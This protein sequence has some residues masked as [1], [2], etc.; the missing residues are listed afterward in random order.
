MINRIVESLIEKRLNKG[1]AIILLGP[2]QTGKTTLL[3][4]IAEK[5]GKF[6]MLNCDD[7]FIRGQLENANAEQLRHLIGSYHLVVIDEAQRVKNIGITLKL[8]TDSMKKV[9]IL[10]SGSSALELAN[11]INEPLTGRKWEFML[12]PISWQELQDYAGYISSKQQLEQRIIY[13]MYPEVINNKGDEIAVLKQLT[14]SYLYKDLLSFKGIRKPEL[15]E[16]LLIALALQVCNE[17]SYNELA[18]LLGIDKNTVASYIDLLEKAYVIF[19]LPAFSRNLR[20]EISSGRKIYFYDTGI[21]NS[22]I[23]NFNPLIMRNDKG[24]L[25]ENFIIAERMKFIHYNSIYCNKYFWRTH[26][27]QEIDYIEEREGN[28]FAFEFKWRPDK[29][30]R[31][32]NSFIRAYPQAEFSVITPETMHKFI[33]PQKR[34]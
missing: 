6:L 17:V 14:S 20:N 3:V 7:P 11:E 15:L 16:K 13:G 2:R 29:T 27:K 5:A 26:Q 31:P 28:L 4:K 10:A 21:R 24:A 33:L 22:V 30:V 8:I 18:G 1:K 12:Y 23:N 19:R 9:Q 32:G 34:G 25:W